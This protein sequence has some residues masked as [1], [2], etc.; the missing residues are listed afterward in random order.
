MQI[1][2][3]L[4]FSLSL[5]LSLLIFFS[6]FHIPCF[7]GSNKGISKDIENGDLRFKPQDG[8]DNNADDGQEVYVMFIRIFVNQ[9]TNWL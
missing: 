8:G 5:T 7:L 3:S 9:E 2:L 4:T 6:L 1:D